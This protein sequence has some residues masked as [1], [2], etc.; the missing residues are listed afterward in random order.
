M[1]IA[2]SDLARLSSV[3]RSESRELARLSSVAVVVG[4][5]AACSVPVVEFTPIQRD[6]VAEVPVTPRR[7]LDV[8][9][10]ID[11]SITMADK[12]LSFRN[13]V[14]SLLNRLS[15]LEG[16]LPNVHFGV[17]STDMGVKA[18]QGVP[19]PSLPPTCNG[20]GDNGNLQTNNAP[21]TGVFISDIKQPDGSRV[22][23]YTGSLASVLGTMTALGVNGCGF[24]QPFASMRAALGNNPTNQGFLRT[25]AFL[26]VYF[27][28]DEDDCSARDP[29]LFTPDET[30]P[31]GPLNSFRCTRFGVECSQGGASPDEMN[32]EGMK[33]DCFASGDSGLDSA[34]MFASFLKGLKARPEDVI[35]GGLMGDAR[36][37]IVQLEGNPLEPGVKESCTYTGSGGT[38]EIADPGIRIESLFDLFPDRASFG[39]ICAVDTR[40]SLDAYGEMILRAMGSP[41][42][43]VNLFDTNNELP[44]IQPDCNVEDFVGDE[45]VFVPDCLDAPPTCWRLVVDQVLCPNA[46]HLKLVV[47]RAPGPVDPATITRMACRLEQ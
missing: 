16:G 3:A 17:A 41:C 18:S 32:K 19:G 12:Q 8:L 25:N 46:D 5:V 14:P 1:R 15:Q 4:I 13:N 40:S 30:G 22:T 33:D 29:E 9:F 47:N 34:D 20:A 45:S 23:N 38:S 6:L 11:D 2:I 35:V 21:V 37:V 28:T 36:P 24:E 31:F 7:E 27:L 39:S 43:N 42:I 10:V 26:A 44:G